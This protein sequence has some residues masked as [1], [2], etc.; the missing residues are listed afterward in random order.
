MQFKAGSK[1][2][3][4]EIVELIGHGGMGAVYKARHLYLNKIRAIKVINTVLAEESK[5][6]ERFVREARILSELNHP[7]LVRL[8][9]F[10]TLEDGNFFMVM[11]FVNG[12]SIR[13]KLQ[14]N[15]KLPIEQ[16]IH[17]TVEAASGLHS[18]HEL[19]IIHRDISPDNILLVRDSHGNEMTKV[20]DFGIAK[21]L[22]EES[23]FTATNIFI[24][25]P[26][27]CSP[28]QSGVN[29]EI[30]GIDCRSDIYSLAV[31]F[32]QMIS[33]QLPFSSATPQGYLLKHATEPPQPIS[34]HFA[35][36]E[37]SADLE[38]VIGTALNKKPGD[39]FSTMKEFADE[40]AGSVRTSTRTQSEP[41][42][43]ISKAETISRSRPILMW[44][45]ATSLVFLVALIAILY[46]FRRT[47]TTNQEEPQVT[48]KAETGKQTDAQRNQPPEKKSAIDEPNDGKMLLQEAKSAYNAGD[49]NL[50]T[51]KLKQLEARKIQGFE[52]EIATLKEKIRIDSEFR[53]T[54]DK[55]QTPLMLEIIRGNEAGARDLI[56]RGSDVNAV[57]GN[58]STALMYALRKAPALVDPLIRSGANVNTRDKRGSTALHVTA[59]TGNVPSTILLLAAGSELDVQD[60]DGATP[61]ILASAKGNT[62]IVQMLIG[63]GANL[64]LT[65]AS[66]DDALKTA[67]RNNHTEIA[68]R[69]RE[70]LSKSRS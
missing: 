28:E 14:R 68:N 13:D 70:S 42:Q 55:T 65:T 50:A 33:G 63:A 59:E 15:T 61:L 12:E 54:A 20:I 35:P 45:M 4:Y 56:Q 30:T 47:E 40:L 44:I 31:T 46:A 5:Y 58:G 60:V 48:K 7:N 1:I 52:S 27:Y 9:E 23:R 10:G 36:G 2:R 29:M 53:A 41:I 39:R 6:V 34:S 49:I 32:Y 38:R 11:E 8:F 17:I 62:T 26:Q 3:E 25:K 64:R 51:E 18:A 69:I 24:G 37:I 67:E 66:G 21:P 19:G 43:R 57:D 22:M 16:A